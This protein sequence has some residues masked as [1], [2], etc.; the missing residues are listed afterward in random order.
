M[1]KMWDW[2]VIATKWIAK[3]LPQPVAVLIHMFP[4]TSTCTPDPSERRMQKRNRG[5]NIRIYFLCR[6]KSCSSREWIAATISLNATSDFLFTSSRRRCLE[7]TWEFP[8]SQ[9]NQRTRSSSH[10]KSTHLIH[11]TKWRNNNKWGRRCITDVPLNH[12][13][14]FYQLSRW[15]N[16]Y[17]WL[18][19]LARSHCQESS[20]ARK[21]KK[22]QNS[23]NFMRS[24]H[25]PTERKAQNIVFYFNWMTPGQLWFSTMCVGTSN[26]LPAHRAVLGLLMAVYNK[27]LHASRSPFYGCT[28][29]WSSSRRRN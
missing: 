14:M 5:I 8:L 28:Y 2:C 27:A 9:T 7:L 26:K 25:D 12:Q 18:E 17:I 23:N 21:S 16:H 15:F 3:N 1:N 20:T 11:S 10:K 4:V 19:Q 13:F 6:S 22:L 29:R 24:F